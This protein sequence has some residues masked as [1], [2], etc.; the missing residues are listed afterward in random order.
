MKT[1]ILNLLLAS[2]GAPIVSAIDCT[3]YSN[4][5]A[6]DNVIVCCPGKYKADAK[7]AVCH[8]AVAVLDPDYSE[9]VGAPSETTVSSGLVESTVTNTGTASTAA[10]TD[11]AVSTATAPD[12]SATEDATQSFASALTLSIT[13]SASNDPATATNTIGAAVATR[14]PL[15]GVAVGAGIAAA[16]WYGF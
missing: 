8:P 10:G 1:S 5:I 11:T 13:A 15:L 16:G 14:A 6:Q 4:I 7:N 2:T 9:K 12:A 3:G